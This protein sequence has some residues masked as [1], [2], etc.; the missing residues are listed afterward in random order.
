MKNDSK[1]LILYNSKKKYQFVFSFQVIEHFTD[2]NLFVKKIS[3]FVRD[4]SDLLI[5]NVY[6]LKTP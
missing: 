6:F 5:I 3:Q 4:V 2:V 1:N